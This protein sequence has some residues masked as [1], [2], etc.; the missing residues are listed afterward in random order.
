V[1]TVRAKDGSKKLQSE[2]IPQEVKDRFR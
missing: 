1:W 2:K